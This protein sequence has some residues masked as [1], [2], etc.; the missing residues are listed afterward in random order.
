MNTEHGYLTPDY[1][2][3]RAPESAGAGDRIAYELDGL[4]LEGQV[5][6]RIGHNL[7]VLRDGVQQGLERV[8]VKEVTEVLS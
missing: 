1:E 5:H 6:L 2:P 4:M 8:S 3:R 7:F